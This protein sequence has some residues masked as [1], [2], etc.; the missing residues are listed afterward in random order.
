[1]KRIIVAVFLAVLLLGLMA[2]QSDTNSSRN[3]TED[4]I[5]DEIYKTLVNKENKLPDNWLD[6]IELVTTDNSLGE[7][8]QVERVTLANFEALRDELLKE[9]VDIELDS[10]YRSIE[11]Q[12]ALWEEWAEEEGEEYC[13]KYLAAPG[14]SEHHTGLAIDIFI[15]KDGKAIR[16]NEEM[17]ADVEDFARIH[18]LIADYGFIL[19]YPRGKEDITGYDYEPWHL[20]F[21]GQPAADIIYSRGITLEEYLENER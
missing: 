5:Q 8:F 20:R 19:R 18:R 11:E 12:E 21:V 4:R 6:E 3:S 17:I 13:Q 2:C 16:D 10:T 9:D 1:M 15:M 14:Y 7:E